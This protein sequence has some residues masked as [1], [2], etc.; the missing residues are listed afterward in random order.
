[1]PPVPVVRSIWSN[2][3][4]KWRES[5]YKNAPGVFC[6]FTAARKIRG[7]SFLFVPNE[8]G[9]RVKRVDGV[10]GTPPEYRKAD[11]SV[12]PKVN[13]NNSNE[14]YIPIN[15]AVNPVCIYQGMSLLSARCSALM[16]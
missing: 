15:K 3:V 14:H 5:G 2:F 8:G 1:M 9:L 7:R 12:F 10:Q 16:K 6:K 11:G 13:N 4:P